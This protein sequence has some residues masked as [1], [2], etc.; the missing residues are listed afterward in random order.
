VYGRTGEE[1]GHIS[2]DRRFAEQPPEVER[3]PPEIERILLRDEITPDGLHTGDLANCVFEIAG[4]REVL[5]TTVPLHFEPEWPRLAA[6][7]L[8]DEAASGVLVTCMRRHA[9]RSAQD[10]I[11]VR[12]RRPEKAG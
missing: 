5:C 7:P 9:L 1:L 11:A 4:C 6:L 12:W 10:A 2:V 8:D 3:L